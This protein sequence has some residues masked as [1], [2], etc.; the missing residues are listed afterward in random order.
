MMELQTKNIIDE[1]TRKTQLNLGLDF[2]SKVQYEKYYFFNL[3]DIICNKSY[4][5]EPH[6]VSLMR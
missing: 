5:G 1:Q 6:Q 4:S 2:L 3:K